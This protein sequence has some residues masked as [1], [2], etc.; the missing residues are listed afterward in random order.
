MPTTWLLQQMCA[1][2]NGEMNQPI[3]SS[4]V[5]TCL[6]AHTIEAHIAEGSRTVF[7]LAYRHRF[8]GPLRFF[9]MMA[10]A[11]FYVERLQ[12]GAGRAVGSAAGQPASVFDGSRFVELPPDVCCAAVENADFSQANEK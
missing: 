8:K 2:W 11:G 4:R 10:K 6:L 3:W 7:I 1:F 5:S 9:S 12:D